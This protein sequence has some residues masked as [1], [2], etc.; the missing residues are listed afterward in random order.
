MCAQSFSHVQLF[1]APQTVALWAP[2][3]MEFSREE[4]WSGVPFPR[5]G[6]LPDQGME[7]ASLE[8]EKDTLNMEW[9]MQLYR[10]FRELTQ[11]TVHICQK[12]QQTRSEDAVSL[13]SGV[14]EAL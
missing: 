12:V 1:A 6:D 4:S 8:Y 13:L 5:P 9:D 3:T 2:L 11:E 14:S 7:L 10:G